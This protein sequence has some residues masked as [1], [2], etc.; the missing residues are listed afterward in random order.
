MSGKSFQRASSWYGLVQFGCYIAGGYLLYA[1]VQ[2]S[3]LGL[4]AEGWGELWVNSSAVAI[5]AIEAAISIYVVSPDNWDD[6]YQ[7]LAGMGGTGDRK[8]LPSW[9][10]IL[11][12][13][14]IVGLVFA[15]CLGAYVF[16]WYSNFAG[17]YGPGAE[18]T[19][20]RLLFC[21]AISLGTEVCAFLGHQVGRLGK[22]AKQDQ[23]REA[24][25]IEPQNIYATEMRKHRNMVA[26]QAARDQIRQEKAAYAEQFRR[27]RQSAP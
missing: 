14:L 5:A 2:L 1:N 20:K 7:S 22:I 24:M 4:A 10:K 9:L 12:S 19:Q 21:L 16:D 15:I 18:V 17:L 23:L 25:E 26:R 8:A 13:A 3:R 6:I 27:E 11:L